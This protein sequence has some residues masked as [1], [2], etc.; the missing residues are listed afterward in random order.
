MRK[1]LVI[2]VT[3][4][5]LLSSTAAQA[6]N[7]T[8]GREA[9]AF[10]TRALQSHLMVAAISCG[11]QANYNEFMQKHGKSLAAEGRVLQEYF[12]RV[13]AKRATGELNRFITFLANESSKRSLKVED[14]EFCSASKKLFSKLNKND[15]AKFFQL[16][17]TASYKDVHG[18]KECK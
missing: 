17:S 11:Q 8:S 7:C 15:S 12:S 4:I 3:C 13:Y 10:N 9:K 16:A 5:G 6:G 2:M 1:Q 14:S 18:V